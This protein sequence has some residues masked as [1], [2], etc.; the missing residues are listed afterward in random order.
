MLAFRKESRGPLSHQEF[1]QNKS[2]LIYK[3]GVRKLGGNRDIG[4]IDVVMG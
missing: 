3:E 2:G 1:S 4:G